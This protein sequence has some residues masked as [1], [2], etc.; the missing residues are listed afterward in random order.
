MVQVASLRDSG[1]PLAEAL[2]TIITKTG[3]SE[4]TVVRRAHA[5]MSL[6]AA[7]D[8]GVVNRNAGLEPGG[9]GTAGTPIAG[10]VDEISQAFDIPSIGLDSPHSEVEDSRSPWFFQGLEL[11]SQ[12]VAETTDEPQESNT[13]GRRADAVSVLEPPSLL[14]RTLDKLNISTVGDVLDLKLQNLREI[15]GVGRL[16]VAQ[17]KDLILEAE[18]WTGIETSG[19]EEDTD[20][21]HT[22][23]HVR[24]DDP[25][26]PALVRLSNK[27]KTALEKAGYETLADIRDNLSNL[28]DLPKLGRTT[29]AQIREHFAEL[30][31]TG[32]EAYLFGELGAPYS[33][34]NLLQRAFA[35][36]D[37]RE[38]D[39]VN[40]HELGDETLEEIG[41][42]YDLT[43]ERVRQI[44]ARRWTE[45]SELYAE[46]AT[47]LLAPEL[48][49]LERPGNLM[50]CRTIDEAKRLD[51]AIQLTG[52]DP[53]RHKRVLSKN[54]REEFERQISALR[55]ALEEAGQTTM[56][57]E[58]ALD[59][60]ESVGI[61]IERDELMRLLEDHWK[62]TFVEGRVV[63]PWFNIGDILA[64]EL[65]ELGHAS[66]IREILVGYDARRAMPEWPDLPEL[67]D[68]AARS[69]IARTPVVW[70]MAH[71]LYIHQDRLP[72]PIED[73]HQAVEWALDFMKGRQDAIGANTIIDEMSHQRVL[74][75][76]MTPHLLKDGI[77]R[78]RL[79]RTFKNN[80]LVAHMDYFTEEGLSLKDRVTKFLDEANELVHWRTVSKGLRPYGFAQTSIYQMISEDPDFV[81]TGHGNY[82]TLAHLGFTTASRDAL[83]ESVLTLLPENG[84]VRRSDEVLA[85]LSGELKD[86]I[87]AHENSLQVLEW[88]SRLD[89]R[90]DAAHGLMAR[91][92][93]GGLV[94]EAIYSIL[95]RLGAAYPHELR[96]RLVED[97]GYRGT[98]AAVYGGLSRLLAANRIMKLPGGLYSIVGTTEVMTWNIWEKRRELV[99]S[100]AIHSEAATYDPT[101]M[102]SLISYI[103]RQVDDDPLAARLLG[104]YLKRS[105]LSPDQRRNA[106][107][108][109]FALSM[110]MN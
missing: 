36:L 13:A 51:L 27:A 90:V 87:T 88:I 78:H 60:A 7:C 48:A 5:L 71:G 96:S 28:V 10:V 52:Y 20:V 18:A 86:V 19:L 73:L 33:V 84:D 46:V 34:E 42:S 69:H 12:S 39:M 72:F 56:D 23:H 92:E 83:I 30:T 82:T 40:R 64:E 45:L 26:R 29:V 70:N 47:D 95:T 54:E 97:F 61:M 66:D 21:D 94:R 77:Y 109:K 93:N 53:P 9:P 22:W 101:A 14:L 43:R 41:Q 1:T 35:D 44:I 102:W 49:R 79:G 15:P 68:H 16:K 76:G 58:D 100:T 89:G 62:V 25:W 4:S 2:Q 6:A 107:D 32:T 98:D 37:E 65:L 85:G 104:E 81:A 74:P 99:V 110:G 8:V 55:A 106:S 91:G 63:F 59:I 50:V 57:L 31:S 38:R 80:L 108:L 75:A 24:P 17:L 105:D 11:A 3:L 103:E 67:N